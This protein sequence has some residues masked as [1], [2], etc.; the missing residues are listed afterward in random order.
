MADDK[1]TDLKNALDDIQKKHDKMVADM[2]KGITINV[3]D[4]D[5][6]K[7]VSDNMDDVRKKT[8]E[9]DDQFSSTFS[10]AIAAIETFNDLTIKAATTGF[11]AWTRSGKAVDNMVSSLDKAGYSGTAS[12]LKFFAAIPGAID[13]TTRPTRE[14]KENLIGIG[15][16]FGDEFSQTM[17]PLANYENAILLAKGYTYENINALQ[18]YTQEL[19][20][21]GFSLEQITRD[22]DVAGTKQNIL[23]EALL[24]AKDTGLSTNSVINMLSV[25][26]R[27]MGNTLENAGTPIAALASLARDTNLPISELQ[28]TVFSTANE[29]ARYGTTIDS[30]SPIVRRFKDTLGEGFKGLAAKEGTELIEGLAGQIN[31]ANSAFIA[32]RGGLSQGQGGVAGAMLDF[33]AA[34]DKPEQIIQSLATTLGSITGGKIIK[35]E[36]ARANPELA[37]QFK[38]QRDLLSQLTGVQ[39]PQQTRT[40]LDVLSNLQSGKS[41]TTEQTRSVGDLLKSGQQKDDETRSNQEKFNKTATTLLAYIGLS[42]A[43]TADNLMS[44]VGIGPQQTGTLARRTENVGNAALTTGNNIFNEATSDLLSAALSSGLGVGADKLKDTIANFAMPTSGITESQRATMLPANEQYTR[45]LTPAATDT[46]DKNG[47]RVHKEAPTAEHTQKVVIEFLSNGGDKLT[48]AIRDM[49]NDAIK[50][51]NKG[52]GQRVDK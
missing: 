28:N 14:M 41:L 50:N 6:L 22:F 32:L 2:A 49:I 47:K 24:I 40:L 15:N 4:L 10:G 44:A 26:T 30:I 20:Q 13:A 25:S 35:F 16:V 48:A 12:V 5:K 33:E 29:F 17:A 42:S 34:F 37:T 31:K 9:A 18:E 45:S 19:A 43:R 11:D 27:T 23:T 36:E 51:A 1:L 52:G 38:L 7:N 3:K 8:K 21:A 46:T 39:G